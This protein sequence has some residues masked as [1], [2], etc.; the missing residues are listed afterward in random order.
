[1]AKADVIV[2][3]V[4]AIGSAALHHLARRGR[5]V[6]GIDRYAPPHPFGS[7]HGETR[8]TRTAIGE[9]IEYAPLALRSHALWRELE[10]ATGETLM[11]QCGCL[12][13]TG[14]AASAIRGVT[15]FL[16]NMQAAAGRHDIPHRLFDS[17]AAIR[18]RFPQFAA[19]DDE[20]AFLDES[21]GYL[22]PEACIRAQIA[23][24]R[25]HGA[26]LRTN[27]TVTRFIASPSGVRVES[28][29]GQSFEAE[30]L[31]I[32]AG[33]WL[34]GLLGPAF[35]DLFRVTRQV[36]A[37]FEIR[38]RA[39]RFSASRFPVFIWQVSGN[40]EI[41][42]DIYGFPLIGDAGA[43]LKIA[44][45]EDD[46]EVDPDR[47]VRTVGADEIQRAYATYVAPF[48]PEVGPRCIKT[49]VCLYTRAAGARF[50]IDTHPEHERIMFASACSGHGF[51]HS[52]AIGEAL[53]DIL[54]DR[55]P[56]VDLARFRLGST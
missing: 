54:S 37:W 50:V 34:P 40:P 30:R 15:D 11:V 1:M 18:G 38:S 51:K 6:V 43:A 21:G 47:V 46:G 22:F 52:A 8:I 55:D 4:G 45:E 13:I 19:R 27:M 48:F 12:V 56:Q 26:A 53:A 20:R 49:D 10:R 14:R 16:G 17:G 42:S 9:G 23:L 7:S 29:N 35:K 28:D 25:Q 32:T 39:E 44:H 2:L 31:L 5:S 36:L 33:A 24:A 41:R 3:G